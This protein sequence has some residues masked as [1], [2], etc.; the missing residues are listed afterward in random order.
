MVS[1]RL[2]DE[3]TLRL[4]GSGMVVMVT[5]RFTTTKAGITT[6]HSEEDFQFQ[7]LFRRLL[8]VIA[9]TA[10]KKA[11]RAHMES[12]KDFVEFIYPPAGR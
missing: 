3:L 5:D 8:S 7:G 11:H 12:F 9:R 6:L 2:P 10:I 1:A 4:D